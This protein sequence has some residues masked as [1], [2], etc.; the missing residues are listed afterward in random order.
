MFQFI[1]VLII[2][3]LAGVEVDLFIPSFPEM[4]QVFH[5]SPFQVQLTLSV[6]FLAFCICSLFAGTLGDRFNRRTIILGGLI[7]FVLGSLLCVSAVNIDMLILGR[8]FQGTGIAGPAVL[9][10]AVIADTYPIEKQASMLGILNGIITIAMAFAP[11]IG[12]YVN[13]YF[14]WHG[15]F[16]LLLS[17][18][19]IC[20]ITS[21]I[22]LPSRKGDPSIRLSPKSYWP[23]LCSRKLMT[24]IACICFAITPYWV[25]VGMSSILYME[26]LGVSLKQFGFYQGAI[27]AVFSIL[28]L[29]SP[30]IL[31]AFG[32]R[33]CLYTGIIL[34]GVAII[35]ILLIALFQVHNPLI[36]TGAMLILAAG[37]LFP[38]NISFP[39]AVDVIENAKG[40]STALIQAGRLLLSSLCLQLVSYFYHGTFLPIGLV[41]TIFLSLSLILITVLIRKQWLTLHS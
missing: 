17:L 33:R 29:L 7:L 1:I 15:N 39:L 31:A 28:S 2:C 10:Y 11:T 18:G 36:I 26:S 6:N 40:R 8:F 32:Q 4:R 30:K 41:M 13:L 24:F 16:V 27:A 37:I 14:G 35:F 38:I 3:I 34:T 22:G 19:I 20:L 23:L 25:F 21:A 12:S 9:G 5:L